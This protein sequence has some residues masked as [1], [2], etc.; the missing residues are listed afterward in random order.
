MTVVDGL[1]NI[2]LGSKFSSVCNTLDRLS[3]QSDEYE[4]VGDGADYIR[5]ERLVRKDRSPVFWE[6]FFLMIA[7]GV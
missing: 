3:R 5:Y 2:V 4:A 1:K 6:S 7:A